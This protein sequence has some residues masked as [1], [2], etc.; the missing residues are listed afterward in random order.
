[1]N[2]PVLTADVLF[3]E[4]IH[5]TSPRPLV[6]INGCHT[7]AVEPEKVVEFVTALVGSAQAS[8]V[9]GTEVTVFEPLATVFGL[10][11]LQRFFAGASI[12]DSVRDARLALLKQG[13]PLGLVYVPFARA[14]LRLAHA[15]ATGLAAGRAHPG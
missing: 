15:D 4:R 12:G 9:I 8:G 3:S 7:V 14:G 5:W 1:L 10:E 6:V 2:G 11:C 13:N